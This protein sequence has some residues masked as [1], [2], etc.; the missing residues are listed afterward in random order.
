MLAYTYE[1][2]QY[3]VASMAHIWHIS[4][5]VEDIIALQPLILTAIGGVGPVE[6]VYRAVRRRFWL[7]IER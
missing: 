5:T 2:Y 1:Y 6:E 4:P 3:S 7:Q